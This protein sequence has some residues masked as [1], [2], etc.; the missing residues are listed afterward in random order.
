MDKSFQ[1]FYAPSG[2]VMIPWTAPTE[3]PSGQVGQ[4]LSDFY[5][6]GMRL[7]G[8]GEWTDQF[9]EQALFEWSYSTAGD[10]DGTFWDLS[11]MLTDNNA[12]DPGVG[13]GAWPRT[14]NCPGK[15][16]W[17]WAAP[18]DQCWTNPD[19]DQIG[20]PANLGCYQGVVDFDVTYCP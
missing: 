10:A 12:H 6:T 19:Q 20:S 3:I 1:I 8:H 14:L 18:L 2:T 7:S 17:P 11:M 5:W 15:I 13:I 4:L 16:C 9:Q